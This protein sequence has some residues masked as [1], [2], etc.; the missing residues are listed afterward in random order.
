[1]AVFPPQAVQQA[2]DHVARQRDA[3]HR[4][5][6]RIKLTWGSSPAGQR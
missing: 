6:Q 4:V 1:L 3:V 2:I 5:Q